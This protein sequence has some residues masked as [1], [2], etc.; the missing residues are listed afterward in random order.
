MNK[1]RLGLDSIVVQRFGIDTT[2]I[3][4][5]KAMMDIENGKYFILNS[6]GSSVWDFIVQPN[7]VKNIIFK[8][9]EE[10]DVDND[11]CEK[12]VFQLLER[13]KYEELINIM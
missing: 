12:S 7:S 9:I 8:L 1:N 11:T 6:V 10:Y 4:G 13:L 3:D 2:D 5:E